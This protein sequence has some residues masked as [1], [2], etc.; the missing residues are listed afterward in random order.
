MNKAFSRYCE[1]KTMVEESGKA[2]CSLKQYLY[3][4]QVMGKEEEAWEKY[5]DE[6]YQWLNNIEKVI[7]E[8]VK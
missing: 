6:M 7:I 8:E 3:I 1:L 5:R 4:A 2:S